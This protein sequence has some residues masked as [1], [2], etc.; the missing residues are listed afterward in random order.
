MTYRVIQWSTGNVGRYAVRGI[1]NH[2]ELELAGLWVHNEKK[3][4][5][6]AAEL[7]GLD[8]PTGVLATN[9]VDALLALGADCVCYTATADL[10]PHE[11]VQDLARILRAGV[12]VVS[13]SIVP[14]VWPAHAGEAITGP[15]EDACKEGG[16]S[17]FTSGIDPGFA[18][19]VLPLLLTGVCERV[20][21]IRVQEI[22]NY[23][24]YDQPTVLFDTMG[25]ARP[26]DAQPILL[27]PGVLTLAWG[28]TLQLLAAGLDVEIERVEEWHERIPAPETFEVPSGTVEKGT[29]AGMRFEIRGIVD[30]EPRIV[31]EHITR[32]RE[33]IA[34]DWPAPPGKG[35]Y[36]VLITGS[37]NIRCELSMEGDGGDENSA[38]LIV[39]AMRLLN[40]VPAVCE[41]PPGLLSALDIPILAGRLS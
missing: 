38:G 2:P 3:A 21:S 11:A 37:P 40:A 18:N 39:T 15:L 9:D 34:P 33:D 32:L 30:G 8:E 7:C 29:T 13:S 20:D 41:A 1:V 5:L 19:D 17:C 10:R 27:L 36:T 22:L 6:D 31:I 23:A 24:T 28:G 26:L 35:G 4:G 25:F 14:L 16:A 12:N